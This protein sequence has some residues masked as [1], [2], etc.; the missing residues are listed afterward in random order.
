MTRLIHIKTKIHSHAYPI[1]VTLVFRQFLLSFSKQ[2]V[3]TD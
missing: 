1:Y 3:S 2:C